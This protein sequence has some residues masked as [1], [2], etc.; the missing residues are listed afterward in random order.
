LFS[1]AKN[2]LD[3]VEKNPVQK[4]EKLPHNVE[5]KQIP[6]EEDVIRLLLVADHDTDE[7]D[8]LIVILHTLA[9]ID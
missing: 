6:K 1:Y 2:V 8:L 7:K 4:I 9:R 5:I 3:V